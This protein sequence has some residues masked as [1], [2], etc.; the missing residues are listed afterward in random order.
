MGSV[1][2]MGWKVVS[3]LTLTLL[4]VGTLFVVF[5]VQVVVATEIPDIQPVGVDFQ[6]RI[7][8]HR[9]TAFE[10]EKLKRIVGVLGKGGNFTQIIEGIGLRPPTEEEWAEVVGEA[11][12]VENILINPPEELPSSVDYTK[13]PWFPPIGEQG[14]EASCVCWALG[15]Y[16]KTFQEAKEHGWNL[17]GAEW[18]VEGDYGHPTEA[19]QDRI[20][21]PAFIYNQINGGVDGGCWDVDAINL[22]CSVGVCSW[23]KMPYD[24]ENSTSWPSEEAWRE[25]PLYRGNSS[26]VEWIDLNAT[27][28]L[29]NLKNWI[30]S[31][32]LACIAVGSGKFP[33]LTSDD[34]WTLDNYVSP[35]LTHENTIVGYDDNINYTEE[36][37]LRHGAFKI[38]NSYGVG[39]RWNN[40]T[41]E[42]DPDGCYWISYEAMKQV[43][44]WVE[45]YRDRIGYDPKLMASFR[46]DHPIRGQCDIKFG[47]GNRNAPIQT[48]MLADWYLGGGNHPFCSNSI[49]LDITEFEAAVPSVINQSFFMEVYDRV[50]PVHSGTH[51]WYSDRE[52]KLWSRL[53]Q[54]FDIPETGATLKF[55]SSY[56]IEENWDYGYVEVHNLDTGEWY[57]LQGV[58]T[59][60][61]LPYGYDNPNCPNEFEPTSYN[62]TG[63]WNAF[64]GSSD[65][66]QEV[67]DLTPFANN[68]IELYFTYWTDQGVMGEGWHIDDIEI[69]EIGFFDDVE[70]GP[71]G[72][73]YNGWYMITPVTGTILS[74]SIEYYYCYSSDYLRTKSVSREVPVNTLDG[75][76]VFVEVILREGARG[77]IDMLV[78]SNNYTVVGYRNIGKP[79]N[80]EWIREPSWD[81]PNIL[82]DRDRASPTVGDLDND[83]DY[84]LLISNARIIPPMGYKNI[85]NITHPI[86]ERCPEWDVPNTGS[87]EQNAVLVDLDYDGDL[88]VLV[89]SATSVIGFRNN[90]T[91]NNPEWVREED[92]DL[93]NSILVGGWQ[94][95]TV[96]DLDNDGDFD[97]MMGQ[98]YEGSITAYGYE[99]NGTA[100][101]PSWKRKPEWDTP[102]DLGVA[103]KHKRPALV[104]IDSDGDYDLFSGVGNDI[105]AYENNA[106]SAAA[107]P[108]WNR[109]TEWDFQDVTPNWTR[110]VFVDL[111]EDIHEIEVSNVT[112]S[113]NV[114]GQGC[115]LRI[116]VSLVNYGNHTETFN[117]TIYANTALID[118]FII[119][120]AASGKLGSRLGAI[121]TWDTSGFAKGNYTISAY[122]W[123]IVGETDTANNRFTD[124]DVMISKLGD[125][126]LDSIVNY[127]DAS[128]F[129]QAYI[130]TYNYLADFNQDEIINYKDASLFRTYYIA[131]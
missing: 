43:V 128:L 36:G 95:P 73:T 85:G 125:L 67:M 57:T 15:Y 35:I 1:I 25:A 121:R 81:V 52:N 114:V 46:I 31:G 123:P 70:S 59:V 44:Q 14:P 40:R 86:W 89:S 11:Y 71:N 92:W 7:V 102:V 30:S 65:W 78:G 5:G 66:Y 79:R 124:G 93:E 76:F 119:T 27:E 2:G 51:G 84:D 42:K 38:A 118:T 129:R 111:D 101:N 12:V 91:V 45:F 19:Y 49:V 72:W 26:G 94:C 60:S 21:S 83:G 107:G 99:N 61:T 115:S 4:L 100:R 120:L 126:N 16:M 3:G 80:T 18:V 10:T 104:D 41:W 110:P 88:D 54:T 90:G 113:K 74:F 112:L 34:F 96:A 50:E 47:I 6:V 98:Y 87:Y 22:I 24:P 122:A 62:A 13:S 39:K 127:K 28:G 23:K 58:K 97:I 75:D 130:G 53:N 131:G 77:D 56:S 9:I 33:Y 37:E 109:K 105:I 55:W 68:T 32:H 117:V 63:R 17:T 8:E 108:S 64:T 48:K 69:P 20:F 106:T 116:V 82:G 29:L 103:N